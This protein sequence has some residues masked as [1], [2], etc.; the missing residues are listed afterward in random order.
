MPPQPRV[1]DHAVA[2]LVADNQKPAVSARMQKGE[3]G[4]RSV[5]VEVDAGSHPAKDVEVRVDIEDGSRFATLGDMD[6]GAEATV[7]VAPL[8]DGAQF[9]W[10]DVEGV[11][12]TFGD[13]AGVAT[14]ESRWVCE[15]R[16][17]V[18]KQLYDDGERAVTILGQRQD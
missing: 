10:D 11:T 5:V 4:A 6:S 8:P 12:V 3:N 16:G 17:D 18:P 15:E 9:W 2:Q 13:A 14:W 7:D 1:P